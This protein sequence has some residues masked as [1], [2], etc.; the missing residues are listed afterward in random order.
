[1]RKKLRSIAQTADI[2]SRGRDYSMA[3][4]KF[5]KSMSSQHKGLIALAILLA[6]T[7]F[8][9]WIAVCGMKLDKDGVKILLPW[10]PTSSENWPESLP[11]SR[12]LGGGTYAEFTVELP[13]GE[14]A[15]SLEEAAVLAEKTLNQRLSKLRVSDTKVTRSG[16]VL[17]LE[18]PELDEDSLTFIHY[19]AAKPA[20]LRAVNTKNEV[21][22]TENDIRK[23]TYDT[24]SGSTYTLLLEVK[25]EVVEG[26]RDP[27]GV[28]ILL[29]DESLAPSFTINGNMVRLPVSTNYNVFSNVAF[30]L[31]NGAYQGILTET[32]EGNLEADNTINGLKVILIAAAVLLAAELIAAAV[33]G[34]LTGVAA[35]WAVLCAV[36]INLFIYATV[37]L[38]TLTIGVAVAL[39]AGIVLVCA[40]LNMRV[41]AISKAVSAGALPKPAVKNA[42]RATAAKVWLCQAAVLAVSI[43][44]MLIPAAKAAGYTLASGVFA[45]ACA[46]GLMRLF[47]ACFTTISGK[48]ALYGKEK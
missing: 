8:V 3:N 6:I 33:M 24:A 5:R 46:V 14:T 36:I 41:A 22:M 45:C 9:T 37:V 23:I 44:L 26:L 11:L 18:L 39:I 40:V 13:E 4:T 7:V 10:V 32:D 1:M 15:I 34:R 38:T 27:D 2:T 28:T 21:V 16:N 29:D 48:P 19:I 17:R 30:L 12:A 31:E 20:H 35:F 25:D 43:V 47:L 42:C